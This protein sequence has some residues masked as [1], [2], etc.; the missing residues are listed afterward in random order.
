M[1][2]WLRASV[3]F[4]ILL[5]SGARAVAAQTPAAVVVTGEV[6]HPGAVAWTPEMTVAQAIA[7]AGGLTDRASDNLTVTRHTATQG[8][9]RSVKP[10]FVLQ[11]ADQLQV[12]RR[13]Y[14][15]LGPR[16]T[17]LGE[18]K[19]PGDYVVSAGRDLLG[20]AVTAAGGFTD[21]AGTDI[22]IWRARPGA[23]PISATTDPSSVAIMHV[24]RRAI[25]EHRAQDF[26]AMSDGAAVVVTATA[27]PPPADAAGRVSVGGDVIHPTSLP[28]AGLTIQAAIEQAGGP[29]PTAASIVAVRRASAG[30]VDGSPETVIYQ[31]IADGSIAIVLHDGDTITLQPSRELTLIRY[32]P[33][34]GQRSMT[35]LSGAWV[36]GLTLQKYLD[37][38]NRP[39]PFGAQAPIEVNQVHVERE[40]NHHVQ[41]LTPTPDFLLQPKDVIVVR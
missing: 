16:L 5:S 6:A 35:S 37:D 8:V 33:N 40:V 7:A 14:A 27:P 32:G 24:S 11:P 29:A 18:V 22:Q 19:N 20:R 12:A 39:S 38:I 25:E 13:P 26:A 30:P 3:C 17:V 41:S 1:A 2:P 21:M 9:S 34:P 31:D 36:P 10:T 28:L 15:G 4:G 23:A